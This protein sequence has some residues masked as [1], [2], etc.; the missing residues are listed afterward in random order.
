MTLPEHPHFETVESL[1]E[2][3]ESSKEGLSNAAAERNLAIYGLNE[4]QEKKYNLFYSFLRNLQ[5]FA[6]YVLSDL[7][8]TLALTDNDR[9]I[10]IMGLWYD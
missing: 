9:I 7:F 1:A 10:V 3:L 6:I 8:L 2:A 4:I 5:L